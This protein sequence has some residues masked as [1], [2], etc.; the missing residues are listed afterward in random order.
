MDYS[1]NIRILENK[2]KSL[3]NSKTKEDLEEYTKTMNE[4]RSLRRLAYEET[5]RVDF[6]DDH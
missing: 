2:L 4:L 3:E 1:N 5:Q 6:G